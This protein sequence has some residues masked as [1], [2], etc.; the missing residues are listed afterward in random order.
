MSAL[1][2]LQRWYAARCDGTWEHQ[3]GISI[4]SCD[5]PGWWVKIALA[6]T[7]LRG[8]AFDD[9]GA[10]V[11]RCRAEELRLA[12]SHAARGAEGGDGRQ[13]AADIQDGVHA[14]GVSTARAGCA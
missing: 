2:R 7:P 1:A 12:V 3:H 6:G 10:G 11:G 9:E 13:G 14:W 4:T 8:V 5:N